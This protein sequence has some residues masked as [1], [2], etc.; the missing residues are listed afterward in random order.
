[1]LIP[2]RITFDFDL[3]YTILTDLLMFDD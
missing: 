3:N 1:V 2:K